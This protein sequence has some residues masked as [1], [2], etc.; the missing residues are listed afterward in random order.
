MPFK[1][2]KPQFVITQDIATTG[3][4]ITTLCLPKDKRKRRRIK[5]RIRQMKAAYTAMLYY[6]SE[7]VIGGGIING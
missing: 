2:I 1:N 7:E 4:S 6:H 3:F 5:R